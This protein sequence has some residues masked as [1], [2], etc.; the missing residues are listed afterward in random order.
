MHARSQFL[1]LLI[2]ATTAA[3]SRGSAPQAASSATDEAA[4]RSMG[5]SYTA[6]V[7][8]G[9]FQRVLS[10]YT[11][12][13]VMMPP[14]QPRT[15]GKEAYAAWARPYFDQFS[16]EESI[17]FDEIRIAGDWAVATYTWTLSSTPKAG[18]PSNRAQGK[19][20]GLLQRSADGSWRWSQTIWNMDQRLAPPPKTP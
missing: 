9:D 2:T 17:S 12:D 10:F 13:V 5:P 18:G 20:M 3:C 15:R 4:I 19:G 11:D 1:L 16:T 14:G 8:A 7:T 6:A